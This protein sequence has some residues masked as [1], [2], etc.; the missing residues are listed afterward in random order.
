MF[1]RSAGC[2]VSIL[3]PAISRRQYRLFFEDGQVCLEDL[4]SRNPALVNGA[5]LT[6]TTLKAGDEITLGIHRF[7]LAA[8]AGEHGQGQTEEA[9]AFDTK[10]WAEGEPVSLDVESVRK[11]MPPGPQTISDLF[12]LYDSAREMSGTESID[13]LAPI[14]M[15]RLQERFAPRRM[16]LALVHDEKELTFLRHSSVERDEENAVP[17]DLIHQALEQRPDPATGACEGQAK[18]DIAEEGEDLAFPFRRPGDGR[19]GCGCHHG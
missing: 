4:G 3:D 8:D 17:R 10:S 11:G 7:V 19:G 14:L 15:R 13:G 16:W 9:H 1:G 6:K 2:D 18:F 5:P 12:F